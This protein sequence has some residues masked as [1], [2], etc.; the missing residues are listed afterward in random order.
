MYISIKAIRYGYLDIAAYHRSLVG[1]YRHHRH[2]TQY[3]SFFSAALQDHMRQNTVSSL[4][5]V[6][7][8]ETVKGLE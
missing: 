6:T 3:S 2:L 1:H 7:I 8:L 4:T 5:M